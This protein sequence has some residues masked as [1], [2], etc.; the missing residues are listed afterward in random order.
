MHIIWFYVQSFIFVT[1]CSGPCASNL[2]I[3]PA[4][5]PIVLSNSVP[6]SFQETSFATG[7]VLIEW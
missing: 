2:L 5:E 3:V 7:S 4:E 6:I 1:S